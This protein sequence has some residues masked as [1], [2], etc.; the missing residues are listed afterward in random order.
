M[1]NQ[2]QETYKI[3]AEILTPVHIGDGSELEPLEYVIKDR[4]YKVNIE[5]WLPALS[6]KQ[7]NEF[8]T[9]TGRDYDKKT[10]L[11]ALRKFIRDNIVL[12]KYTE[13]SVDVGDEVRKKYEDRF[14]V[15]ENQLQMSPF[16]RTGNKP[17][18]PGSS[19]KG[20]IR[21][22]YLSFLKDS[23]KTVKEKI[24]ADL[25][26]G[27]LMKANI[28]KRDRTQFAIDKD[29]FRA[30]K[31]KDIFL[32]NGST[33][34]A[35]V[36]NHNKKDNRINPTSIQIMSEVTYGSLINNSVLVEFEISIDSKILSNRGCGIDTI[37]KDITINRILESCDT[38]YKRAL[39]EERT[40]FLQGT[41]GGDHIDKVYQQILDKAEDGYLFRLG[42]GSGLI[43]MT[44]SEE[45]RTERRYGKS[46]NLIN[47]KIPMGFIKIYKLE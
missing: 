34:F 32:P 40:K 41:F 13:W 9:L 15:P 25:V 47:G 27:E 20:A 28:Q 42:W 30:V 2:R 7:T 38:F 36:I 31:V 24:R 3:R 21:T 18:I 45:L 16:V 4:F 5:G 11:T 35:E 23:V 29:P 10:T 43:S 12:E 19:I 26:E 37:H 44:I 14:D 39:D 22:A 46:K 1:N 6:E 8:K 33:F 17:F